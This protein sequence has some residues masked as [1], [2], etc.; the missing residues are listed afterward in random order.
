MF[1]R[2]NDPST[3]NYNRE[4]I[5][6]AFKGVQNNLPHLLP[7]SLSGRDKRAGLKAKGLTKPASMLLKDISM[8]GIP[9]AIGPYIDRYCSKLGA[10]LYYREKGKPVGPDFAL[11]THW[12]QAVDQIQMP[13]LLEVARM[14]PFQTIGGRMNLNFGDRF[15]YR[16]DK[17]DENDLFMAVAQFGQGLVIAMLVADEL[18]A[19][20]MAKDGW[21]KASAMFD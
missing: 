3:E 7:F 4:E 13:G 19:E 5:I 21:V 9:A 2:F 8:V 15:G 14:S 12:A 1:V 11:W 18:P 10:A 20:E 6:K 17:A 16:C